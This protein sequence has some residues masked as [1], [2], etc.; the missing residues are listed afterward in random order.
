MQARF[1]SIIARPREGACPQRE[2]DAKVLRIAHRRLAGN[3][4]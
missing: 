1:P 2:N 3:V 4:V